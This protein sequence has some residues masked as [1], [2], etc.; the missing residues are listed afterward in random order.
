[1]ELKYFRCTNT[2]LTRCLLILIDEDECCVGTF[3]H[4]N[5]SCSDTLG[6]FTCSCNDGFTWN[7]TDCAGMLILPV[8]PHDKLSNYFILCTILL[9]LIK[10]SA[11]EY[12][13]TS[14]LSSFHFNEPTVHSGKVVDR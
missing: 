5:S 7:G 1:M 14:N 12:N 2:V 3:C 10:N 6:G 8:L 4:M 11:C 9:T 13:T